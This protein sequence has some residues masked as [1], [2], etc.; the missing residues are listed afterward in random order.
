MQHTLT[1]C[2]FRWNLAG[3]L[4]EEPEGIDL[5][6]D[7]VDVASSNGP[8]D[9]DAYENRNPDARTADAEGVYHVH[10]GHAANEHQNNG[11]HEDCGIE[12]NHEQDVVA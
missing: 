8:H 6:A 2:F 12:S 7:G 4:L 11:E 9:E 10:I 5:L 3:L 1:D